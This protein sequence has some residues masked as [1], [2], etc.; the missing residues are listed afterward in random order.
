VKSFR[1]PLTFSL[2]RNWLWARTASRRVFCHSPGALIKF[3]FDLLLLFAAAAPGRRLPMLPL[4]TCAQAEAF[5]SLSPRRF[6]WMLFANLL[7]VRFARKKYREL[8]VRVD[9]LS[10]SAWDK[11][12][13]AYLSA[14]DMQIELLYIAA[15]LSLRIFYQAADIQQKRETSCIFAFQSL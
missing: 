11:T 7:P 15:S 14:S 10:G 6:T 2:M 8:P 5:N 12:T 13:F 9:D 1:L 3:L 4:T